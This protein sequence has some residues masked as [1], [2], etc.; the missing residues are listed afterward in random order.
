MDVAGVALATVISQLLSAL[1]VVIALMR[2]GDDAR[3]VLIKMRFYSEPLKRIF[4]MGIPAGVQAS[5]FSVSNVIIQSSLNSLESVYAGVIAGNAAAGSI[6]NFAFM[7]NEGFKQTAMNFA[8]QNVGAGNYVRVKRIGTISIF[9]TTA[10]SVVVGVV[11]T[12]CSKPLLGIYISDSPEAIEWGVIRM[13]CMC[14][15]YFV[16]G[17]MDVTTGLLRGMGQSIFPMFASVLGVC[18]FRVVWIFT[19]FQIPAYH[20]PES[21]W[22]SYIISWALT[23]LIQYIVFKIVVRKKIKQLN[24]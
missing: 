20:T 21:L 5:L 3:L 17:A 13:F 4:R 7:T 16:G 9:A 11:M 15:P 10:V 2:R 8:G 24:R 6:Q 23:F 12:L 14:L 18:V 1:L 22:I 19:V